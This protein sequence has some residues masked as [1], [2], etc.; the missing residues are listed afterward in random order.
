MSQGAVV[1]PWKTEHTFNPQPNSFS[2]S[3]CIT[4]SSLCSIS[5]T[6]AAQGKYRSFLYK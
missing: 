3:S 2:Q 6:S 1:L 5:N 4:V